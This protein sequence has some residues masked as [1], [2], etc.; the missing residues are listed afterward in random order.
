MSLRQVVGLC[1]GAVVV[2]VLVVIQLCFRE[3]S[4][5]EQAERELDPRAA[6]AP[7]VFETPEYRLPPDAV[8][9]SLRASGLP[10]EDR[11]IFPDAFNNAG[12]LVGAMLA[13]ARV[14]SERCD[15]IASAETM[16]DADR[17]STNNL[18]LN[19][20]KGEFRYSFTRLGSGSWS[21]VKMLH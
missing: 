3:P 13:V 20:N 4:A 12:A 21:F 15:T 7:K 2:I 10:V 18:L 8:A 6:Q 5:L 11:A 19:C 17:T 1:L 14:H 16:I 9:R